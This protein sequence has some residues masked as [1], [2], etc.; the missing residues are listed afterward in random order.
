MCSLFNSFELQ[1]LKTLRLSLLQ[2]IHILPDD[3]QNL[4]TPLYYGDKREYLRN[5]SSTAEYLTELGLNPANRG[6]LFAWALYPF[7]V[8]IKEIDYQPVKKIGFLLYFN[9]IY[10]IQKSYIL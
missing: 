10:L 9:K 6:N 7:S 3:I 2:T 5:T 8:G 1:T 4:L